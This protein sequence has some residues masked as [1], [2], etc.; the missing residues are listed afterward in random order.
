MLRT[1]LLI[2]IQTEVL[3]HRY[4]NIPS[5]WTSDLFKLIS[6]EALLSGQK[7]IDLGGK[8]SASHLIFQRIQDNPDF[9]NSRNVRP[10]SGNTQFLKSVIEAHFKWRTGSGF[11]CQK[12]KSGR[13]SYTTSSSRDL[14]SQ[15][16]LIEK[17]L[18]YLNFFNV[19]YEDDIRLNFSFQLAVA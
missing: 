4:Q 17:Y 14:H 2:T 15:S 7:I 6:S 5:G 8:R 13:E 19:A 18:E 1:Y 11:V 3:N 9:N 10:V 16:Y 12:L